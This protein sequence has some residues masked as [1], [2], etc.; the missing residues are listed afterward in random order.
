MRDIFIHETAEVAKESTI[1]S[2]TKIWNWTKVRENAVI[3]EK[4]SIGQCVYIDLDVSI[5][6]RCKIQ[7]GVQIYKGVV[8][9]DDVFIGPNV[10]FTNDKYP[11]AHNNNWVILNTVVEAGV[12][13]G[14][15]AIIIC[16]ITL[17]KNA[18]IAAG[19]VVTKDV[20]ANGLVM[21][22]PAKLVD[23]VSFLGSPAKDSEEK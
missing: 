11:R 10:T 16:G 13:I 8:I 9:Q 2:G 5:G 18:M 14:A 15:G 23:Q 19:S 17:G 12:S 1:K 22:N 21:G 3:G 20:P 7:N 4:C 6:D